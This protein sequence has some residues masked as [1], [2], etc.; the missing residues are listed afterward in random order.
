MRLFCSYYVF[1]SVWILSDK[2]QIFI[3]FFSL[4]GY[5]MMPCIS[6]G[7]LSRRHY[8][9]SNCILLCFNILNQ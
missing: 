2:Q 6:L 7:V 5:S 3:F 9:F 4:A 8:F 1:S